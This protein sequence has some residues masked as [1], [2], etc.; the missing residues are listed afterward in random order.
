MRAT[1]AIASNFQCS[2]GWLDRLLV[3]EGDGWRAPRDAELAG[4]VAE[5]PRMDGAACLFVIPAHMSASFWAMLSEEAAAGAGDF[6]AFVDEL[7]RF[8]AFKELSP[9]DGAMFELLVQDAG[10][11][12]DAADLWALVNLGEEP[13]LL[14]WP[15]LRLRLSPREGCR[16]AANSFPSV[17]PPAE[18]PNVLVAIRLR[19]ATEGPLPAER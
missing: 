5:E 1:F 4:L 14:A 7:S 8:L 9:P 13:V 16:I 19:P 12:V 15:E 10:G 17:V 2:G 18:E 3:A 6:L 11:T